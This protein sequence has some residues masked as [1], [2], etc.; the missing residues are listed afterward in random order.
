MNK[1]IRVSLYLDKRRLKQKTKTYPV[2]LQVYDSETR[3]QK[4]YSTLFE[5]KEEEYTAIMESKKK[6][7]VQR[8]QYIA[9]DAIRERAESIISEMTTFSY[10]TFEK[11]YL[12][13]GKNIN[14]K[15]LIDEEIDFNIENKRHGNADVLKGAKTSFG[16]FVK[17]EF[18][19]TIDDI[20]L[21]DITPKWLSKYQEYMIDELNRKYNTVGIYLRAL[22][23]LYNK[24]ITNEIVKADKYPFSKHSG[25][26]KYQIPSN[27]GKK[28]TLTI[29]QLKTFINSEPDNIY[30]EKA[31]DFLLFI[32][33][34]NG[35]NV[36]DII[37]LKH[38][39]IKKDTIEFIR[40]KTKRTIKEKT[41]IVVYFNDYIEWFLKKYSTKSNN[42]EDFVFDVLSP[43]DT[44]AQ[45]HR[46][47]KNFTK[48]INQHSKKLAKKYDLPEDISTYTARH[49][50]S[51]IGIN[52]GAS[53]EFMQKA[54]GHS[55]IRTTQAYFDG[56]EDE[57]KREFAQNLMNFDD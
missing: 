32:F 13:K 17:H 38:K 44:E 29:E 40:E 18:N 10:E 55:D 53:L 33:N 5:Y 21:L 57:S 36:K 9:L 6:T 19:K 51:T 46:K 28:K 52:K 49:S 42:K 37:L 45:V 1:K 22:R 47:R 26:K 11:K 34:S 12:N 24:A 50:F 3:K 23:A 14:L 35:I 15:Q 43:T 41:E 4:F 2:K 39:N 54:L 48:F 20:T 25:D 56:F 7:I 8:K 30:Q 31:K 16:N 27:K